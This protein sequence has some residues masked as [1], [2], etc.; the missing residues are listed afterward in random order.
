M[1]KLVKIAP[2][3]ERRLDLVFSDGS[4]GTWSAAKIMLCKTVLTRPLEDGAYF[5]RAFISFGALAWPNGLEFSPASLH[6]EL[7]EQGRLEP[8]R[9]A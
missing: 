1:I 9:A 6:Q 3:G 2:A 7:R 5:R 4:R 8:A